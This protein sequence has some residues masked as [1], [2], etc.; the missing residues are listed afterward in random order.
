MGSRVKL[1]Q[2]VEN[3]LAEDG[4]GGMRGCWSLAETTQQ[5]RTD[6]WPD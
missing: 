5:E 2:G 6:Y 1:W 3:E 4:G